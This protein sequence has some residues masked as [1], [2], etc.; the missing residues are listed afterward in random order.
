[1]QTE[2]DRDFDFLRTESAP[3]ESSRQLNLYAIKSL[4]EVYTSEAPVLW[5][6]YV[7]L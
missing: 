7:Y 6:F 5:P 2:R 1:M 3:T 4:C